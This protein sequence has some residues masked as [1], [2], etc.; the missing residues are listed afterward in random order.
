MPDTAF[1]SLHIS[2]RTLE[3]DASNSDVQHSPHQ[4]KKKE[5]KR[6]TKAPEKPLPWVKMPK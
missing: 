5:R 6:K 1:F 2:I 4:K 3:V